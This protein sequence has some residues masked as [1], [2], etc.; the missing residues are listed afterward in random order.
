LNW[1]TE[2]G[3]DFAEPGPNVSGGLTDTQNEDPVTAIWIDISSIAPEGETRTARRAVIDLL[4][5]ETRQ[6]G[7]ITPDDIQQPNKGQRYAEELE[8]SR[9]IIVSNGGLDP[10]QVADRNAY[11]MENLY[12]II[13]Q[14]D[15]GS[16]EP[17]SLTWLVWT[18][19]QGIAVGAERATRDLR[20]T[21]ETICAFSGHANVMTWSV[22]PMGADQT[23][24]TID[25]TIDGIDLTSPLA[26]PDPKEAAAMR[27]WYGA[28]R[29]AIETDSINPDQDTAAAVGRTVI[30]TSMSLNQPLDRLTPQA[31]AALGVRSAQNDL[32]AGY[33]LLGSLTATSA[34][35]AWWRV[36]PASGAADARL[37]D[38]GNFSTDFGGNNYGG[39]GGWNNG[40]RYDISPKPKT[41]PRP[42]S[43]PRRGG[44]VEYSLVVL[45]VGLAVIGGAYAYG[46]HAKRK[47]LAAHKI[48]MDKIHQDPAASP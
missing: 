14:L 7:A 8:S 34:M 32:D 26:A 30:S 28:V 36:D 24:T 17:E 29:S 48:A 44:G 16:I 39:G 1:E 5:F 23:K 47:I 3:S 15:D 38:L 6:S 33:I 35:P 2:I 12:E 46:Q 10:A 40:P 21:D 4:S 13:T 20:S 18:A 25:W 37:A 43:K 41:I 42:A 45:V 9:Q 11:I 19:V 27:L 22:G 31:V